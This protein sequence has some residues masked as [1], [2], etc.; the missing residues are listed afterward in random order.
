MRLLMGG[1]APRDSVDSPRTVPTYPTEHVQFSE[2]VAA[3]GG[4]TRRSRTELGPS[5]LRIVIG[6]LLSLGAAAT[7]AAALYLG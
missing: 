2:E 5:L 6:A 1:V 4:S 3:C 7:Y